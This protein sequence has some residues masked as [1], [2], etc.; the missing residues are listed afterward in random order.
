MKTKLK[1]LAVMLFTLTTA[2]E[3][4]AQFFYNF[5]TPPGPFSGL[6]GPP[7][8]ANLNN[9]VLFVIQ[10]DS[11]VE[12]GV[13]HSGFSAETIFTLPSDGSLGFNLTSVNAHYEYISG[14]DI[15]IATTRTGGM[16]GCGTTF[17]ISFRHLPGTIN[18]RKLV[19]NPCPGIGN[20]PSVTA[21]TPAADGSLNVFGVSPSGGMA[22]GAMKP[23]GTLFDVRLNA[24]GSID[25]SIIKT[26]MGTGLG[27]PPSYPDGNNPIGDVV[28]VPTEPFVIIPMGRGPSPK[29]ANT[30]SNLFTI[31]GV[32]E[33][34]GPAGIGVLYRVSSDGTGFQVLHNF[35]YEATNAALPAG[36]LI[37]VND[38]LY[39]VTSSKIYSINTNGSNFKVFAG[40]NLTGAAG[41]LYWAG[42]TFYGTTWQGLGNSQGT[43]YSVKT[44]GTGYQVLYNFSPLSAGTNSLGLHTNYD[45]AQP[46]S[47][48]ILV[49][50]ILLGTTSK[51]GAN[52]YG[53]LFGVVLGPP[54]ITNQPANQAQDFGDAVTFTVGVDGTPPL[55]YQWLFNGTNIVG[56]TNVVYHLNG[57]A[58]LTSS[59]QLGTYAVIITNAYG[60]VTSSFATLTLSILQNDSFETRD[61]TGW[62]LTGIRQSYPDIGY[63]NGYS[64]GY[65]AYLGEGGT[66]LSY[67][68]QTLPTVAGQAY[69][70][71]FWLNLS[72]ISPTNEFQVTWGGNPLFDGVNLIPDTTTPSAGSAA[73]FYGWTNLQFTVLATGTNT[74]LQFGFLVRN[75]YDFILDDIT[76]V[77]VPVTFS[78][79]TPAL[80][81]Q[82]FN[83]NWSTL[84]GGVY[85]VQYTA[86]LSPPNWQ[87]VGSPFT[88]TS[89]SLST[90]LSPTNQQGYQP[91]EVIVTINYN[92]IVL[93]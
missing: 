4:G 2:L 79:Q 1:L 17:E 48:V 26:F 86:S 44:N 8:A 89:N 23:V 92:C 70:L 63:H 66:N 84:P 47:G 22:A 53:T 39:G 91:V 56:E 15:I 29:A 82:M 71:G 54:V 85:Q 20:N 81:G 40:F 58:G 90:S 27:T 42:D 37:L 33:Y 16:Y 73:P 19:D 3:V 18:I 28:P 75:Y 62:I 5:S 38:T 64:G 41:V 32:T 51:G 13:N 10:G 7:T 52:G 74:V 77:P 12:V 65:A 87:A 83:F 78:V 67:I 60:S 36:G 11:I 57:Y 31:Y 34:G 59:N 30:V 25:Q 21:T 69:R 93:L 45:G 14:L 50:N 80:T 68:S 55:A 46:N 76:V 88:A 43:V 61:F 6:K 24:D 35:G 49:S 9:Q 72:Q